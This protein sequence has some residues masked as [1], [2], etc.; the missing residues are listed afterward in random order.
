MYF[1]HRKGLIEPCVVGPDGRPHPV[2][3]VQQLLE[4]QNL[5]EREKNIED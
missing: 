2:E 3:H 5:D 1:L 4:G